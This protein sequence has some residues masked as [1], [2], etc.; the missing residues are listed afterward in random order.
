MQLCIRVIALVILMM[1]AN[2]VA[3]QTHNFCVVPVLIGDSGE[4]RDGYNVANVKSFPASPW[5]VIYRSNFFSPDGVGWTF[6]G[7]QRLQR[8]EKFPKDEFHDGF[9]EEPSGRIVG[10]WAGPQQQI[11]F[12]DKK[13]GDFIPFDKTDAITIGRVNAAAWITVLNG[14]LIATSKGLYLLKGD[15]LLSVEVD[16]PAGKFSEVY[17][18]PHYKGA[19]LT[20][21]DG[22]LVI[23]DGAEQVHEVADLKITKK[24]DYFIRVDE[25]T[26]TNEL[27]VQA[28]YQNWIVPM[29]SVGE[30]FLPNPAITTASLNRNGAGILR[31]YPSIGQ[32]LVISGYGDMALAGLHRLEKDKLVA[33]DGSQGLTD[34][35]SLKEVPSYHL[36]IV[37]TFTRLYRYDGN[38]PLTPIQDYD[39]AKMG[40][41]PRVHDLPSLGK[42]LVISAGGVFEMAP[43]MSLKP[44]A[45][46]AELEGAKFE[47]LVE[48][49][50]SHVAVVFT[51]RGVFT[52]NANDQLSR[53]AGDRRMDLGSSEPS[54][55]SLIPVREE[56]FVDAH[57]G[58][59]LVRDEIIAGA[60]SCGISK[61]KSPTRQACITPI[62][63]ADDQNIGPLRDMA[64]A[65]SKS[66]ILVSARDG[67]FQI[68]AAGQFSRSILVDHGGNFVA[69]PWNALLMQTPAGP[70]ILDASD[71]IHS[72]EADP[73]YT[74]NLVELNKPE[75][76]P[77]FRTAFWKRGM[78]EQDTYSLGPDGRIMMVG[79]DPSDKFARVES[80]VEL[81]GLDR[82]LVVT[83]AGYRLL[84]TDGTLTTFPIH[85]ESKKFI[86]HQRITWRPWEY[87]D[88]WSMQRFGFI[89]IHWSG[90]GPWLLLT[91]DGEAR[92]A[93]GLPE[94]DLF[95]RGMLDPGR[96]DIVLTG[97][98]GL[99]RINASGTAQ[100]VPGTSEAE[101]GLIN[102][103]MVS[104]WGGGI[105]LGTNRGLYRLNERFIVSQIPGG[106]VGTIGAVS[107]ITPLP[108]LHVVLVESTYG[109]FTYSPDEGV[110]AIPALEPPGRFLR[111]GVFPALSQVLAIGHGKE[112]VM[113]S[114]YRVD[115]GEDC[116]A[117]HASKPTD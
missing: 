106:D 95:F 16:T 49:P 75:F 102:K 82:P 79:P 88:W 37:E 64:E 74:N 111:I 46:P 71:H 63:E 47:Q 94:K 87:V 83:D 77:Q 61:I 32:F 55:V 36:V 11:Y 59:F 34:Y 69:L 72:I 53:V 40:K 105:L 20:T 103:M 33:V 7:S 4:A 80:L 23:L 50:A 91:P 12:Q 54:P 84:N 113:G 116:D 101:M 38:G 52:L 3:A 41:Y 57:N 92:E 45:L 109:V 26:S 97:I 115:L 76:A 68:D 30:S 44:I 99:W 2:N 13:T 31:L 22:R 86:Q 6:A 43:D 81:P 9:A 10:F 107:A 8:N 48:L 67:L 24:S 35:P 112:A 66:R 73:R 90:P 70:A 114:L 62:P 28:A 14:T 98:D 93:Q 110:R 96:G 29:Y 104:P 51:N 25:V 42:V 39:A 58:Q 17:D 1:I 27:L 108:W 85:S 56:L 18:L 117:Q 100:P 19:A 78:G 65:P 21:S 60:G 15:A 89:L 5:P